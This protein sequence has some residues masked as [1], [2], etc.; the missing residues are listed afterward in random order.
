[1]AI[2]L[3]PTIHIGTAPYIQLF[4]ILKKAMGYVIKV[5]SISGDL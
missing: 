1:M 4:A 3:E 2:V 5:C